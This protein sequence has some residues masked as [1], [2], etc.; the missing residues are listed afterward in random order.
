MQRFTGMRVELKT[1]MQYVLELQNYD[2]PFQHIILPTQYLQRKKLRSQQEL[3]L[4][5]YHIALFG[6]HS[7]KES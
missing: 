6:V 2:I 4:K 1:H 7:L 3:P 5:Y